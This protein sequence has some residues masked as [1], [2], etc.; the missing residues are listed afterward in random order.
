ML[1]TDPANRPAGLDPETLPSVNTL[2]CSW[3]PLARPIAVS[4][5]EIF[6]GPDWPT[7]VRE[8]RLVSVATAA[9]GYDLRAVADALPLAQ[10]PSLILVNADPTGAQQPRHLAAFDDCSRILLVGE[11]CHGRAPLRTVLSYAREEP[12]DLILVG[13]RQ[14]AHFF[15]EAGLPNVHWSPAFDLSPHEPPWRDEVERQVTFTG[16]VSAFHGQ[17]RHVLQALERA[18]VVVRTVT[19]SSEE[20]AALRS[21]SLINVHCS[22][23]GEL[24][25]VVF[26]VLAS[27]GFLL[28][29]RLS[30][31]AGLDRL[32]RD[33]EHLVCY[34]EV[35]DL[36]QKIEH[37]LG[38]PDQARRIA[39]AGR[40]QYLAHHRPA[41][42]IAQLMAALAGE[43][44][45]AGVAGEERASHAAS[46][47]MPQ[48]MER[49]AVYEYLQEVHRAEVM[50]SVL[51]TD[52]I[53]ARI[54]ADAIDLPRMRVLIERGPGGAQVGRSLERL[55]IS[56][57]RI[58]C[59]G[60]GEIE[61]G[62]LE[63]DVVVTSGARIASGDVD[64]FVAHT[65]AI[66]LDA[67][68]SA[69]QAAGLG[70]L[71]E[72]GFDRTELAQPHVYH[73]RDEVEMGERHFAAG[74]PEQ[75]SRHFQAA[76][77][78]NPE[79]VRALNDLSVV[80]LLFGEPATC[81]RHLEQALSLDRRDPETLVN[82]AQLKLQTGDAPAARR[83]LKGLEARELPTPVL[84][85]RS[86]ALR[87]E[88]SDPAPG[89][90][91]RPPAALD[92]FRMPA[93]P[94]RRRLRVAFCA[95]LLPESGAP[96][97]VQALIRL[98]ARGLDFTC[99]LAGGWPQ[100]A[101]VRALRKDLRAAGVEHRFQLPGPL[102][103][104]E[105]KNLFARSNVLVAASPAA[106]SP[107]DVT[108][109]EA[110]MAG[111]VAV[112]LG[113]DTPSGIVEHES[114]G[115]LLAPGEV[116]A[117]TDALEGLTRDHDRWRR[118]AEA[119]ERRAAGD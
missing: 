26:E 22:L 96:V 11:T 39:R 47:T 62:M 64:P 74:D 66:V 110:M 113:R 106:G 58:S 46:T 13:P 104:E 61:A 84:R 85:E 116:E 90:P 81:L 40:D 52:G 28:T 94:S 29:D 41:R 51:F 54:V 55:G 1:Y 115:L 15:V 117:L 3:S 27:G 48:V 100:P 8:E 32:F 37:Y 20:A 71:A 42:K 6:C 60:A 67:P 17:R 97:L 68:P 119:G 112:I 72:R 76:L 49:L 14:H 23:N 87:R 65:D 16:P 2:V 102:D 78:A 86:I 107:P 25:R 10:R 24:D 79:D 83:L 93:A 59:P 18:G 33:G 88:L 75:A 36:Q 92:E 108:V 12:F 77:A 118:L 43:G 5:S 98:A 50:P 53:D 31:Q 89:S 34:D 70:R 91:E 38:R 57:D 4:T 19:G 109:P 21:R 95:P 56:G 9:G 45:H 114:T 30:A 103:A 80:S 82:L 73:L 105:R 111:L 63:L 99:T 101:H 44:P 35:E 7:V 69:A